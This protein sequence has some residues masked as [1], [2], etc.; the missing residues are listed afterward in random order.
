MPAAED[1]EIAG[2]MPPTAWGPGKWP[3]TAAACVAVAAEIVLACC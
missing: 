3:A 1:S 2:A